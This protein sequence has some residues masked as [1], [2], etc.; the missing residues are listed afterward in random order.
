[1]LCQARHSKEA[2]PQPMQCGR[3]SMGGG[4]LQAVRSR[5]RGGGKT[6]KRRRREQRPP[7]AGE[8]VE[9]QPRRRTVSGTRARKGE[10]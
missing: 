4:A 2:A 10:E 1:M 6:D 3:S 7:A 5:G 8:G 9:K